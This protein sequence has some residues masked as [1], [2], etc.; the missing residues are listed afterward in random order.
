M[1]L[2]LP[3]EAGASLDPAAFRKLR[4]RTI[5]ECCKWDPQVE[6]TSVLA[7]Y[8]VVLPVAAWREIAA[9]AEQLSVETIAAERELL[10]RPDLLK[11]L[12]LPRTIW[13]LLASGAPSISGPRVMRFDFHFTPEGWRISEVNSD[14]PGGFVE[15]D[16]F[17]RLMAEAFGLAPT[18]LPAAFLAQTLVHNVKAETPVI[19]FA[20]ATAYSDD[21][22][23]MTCLALE[24]EKL[25][26][27]SV[28]I[29]PSQIR[30]SE[31]PATGAR[32][33]SE[34]FRGEANLIYRFFPAEWLPNLRRTCSWPYYFTNAHTPQSNPGWSLL[35]QSKRFGLML[36]RLSTPVPLWKRLLPETV[37][38]RRA[39]SRDENWVFKPALGRVG[40]AIGILG[41]TP[42][43]EWIQIRRHLFFFPGHWV[44]QRRFQ[45]VPLPTPEGPRYLCLGVYTINGRAAGIYARC[46]PQPIINHTA[47]DVAV[48]LK[49]DS[50]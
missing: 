25:G 40:E 20:H 1:S 24:V 9:L 16:G 31:L 14:V 6:D 4:L 29:D 28:L 41:L 44:A 33:E 50:L 38:V 49:G 18:G 35:S 36:D 13:K 48:L 21:R 47:Q 15:A 39:E 22:Q 26:A 46:S 17:T 45:I 34:W 8:P 3:F 43:R 12:G 7:P 5:F 11:D 42:A 27:R 37:D 19:A 2:S 32:I 30:W 10:S 23:V